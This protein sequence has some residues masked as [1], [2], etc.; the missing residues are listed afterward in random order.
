MVLTENDAAELQPA[1]ID[2]EVHD[3]VELAGAA[4]DLLDHRVGERLSPRP[5]MLEFGLE[6]GDAFGRSVL[7]DEVI[8]L[9]PALASL[10]QANRWTDLGGLAMCGGRCRAGVPHGHWKATT[11]TA[12]LR[13]DGPVAPLVL[14]WPMTGAAFRAYVEQALVP[15]LTPGDVV[16]MDNLPA[17]KARGVREAIESA[18]ATLLFLPPYSRASTRSSWPSSSRRC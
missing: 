4:A 7:P 6:P 17:H 10:V 5:K 11:F 18:G 3:G 12:G 16:A 2:Q 1:L 14:D 9:I 15:E 8:V 13:L